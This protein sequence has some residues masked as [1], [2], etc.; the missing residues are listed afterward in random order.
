MSKTAVH[1]NITMKD[2]NIMEK[3]LPK[4]FLLNS[5]RK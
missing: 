1:Y 2:M 4:T 3:L 5:D